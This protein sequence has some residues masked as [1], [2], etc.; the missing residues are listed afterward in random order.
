MNRGR[1]DKLAPDLKK[2]I[3]DTTGL[4]LSLKGAA[5]YDKKGNEAI[6]DAKR[7]KSEVFSLAEAERK[8]WVAAFKPMIERQV[9]EAEKQGL[10]A[11]GLVQAYGLL[12]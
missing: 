8:R 7:R 4:E 6:A 10:P 12:A 1:Y 9:A 3:D 11:K 5:T 2:I